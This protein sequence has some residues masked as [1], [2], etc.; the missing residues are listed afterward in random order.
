MKEV[1]VVAIEVVHDYGEAVPTFPKYIL[2]LGISQGVCQV[3]DKMSHLPF[4]P[5]YVQIILPESGTYLFCI[6]GSTFSIYQQCQQFLGLTA[7]K[8]KRQTVHKYFKIAKALHTYSLTTFM[9]HKALF[10]VI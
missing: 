10:Y 6:H 2:C 3:R 7:C 4:L 8:P 1:I 5:R 9:P